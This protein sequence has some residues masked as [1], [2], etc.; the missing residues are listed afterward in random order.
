M[1]WCVEIKAST[2]QVLL[3]NCSTL[4]RDLDYKYHNE[5]FSGYTGYGMRSSPLLHRALGFTATSQYRGGLGFTSQE[6]WV[7]ITP[8]R[9]SPTCSSP[10]IENKVTV[11]PFS[12]TKGMDSSPDRCLL[13][14]STLELEVQL[15]QPLSPILEMLVDPFLLK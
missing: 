7:W 2:C 8:S 13:P 4:S 15:T 5:I 1:L 12:L 11:A 3:S 10:R 14:Y 9:Q 6:G